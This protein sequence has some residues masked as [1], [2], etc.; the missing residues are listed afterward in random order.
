M[1]VLL[2]VSLE[3]RPP[4]QRFEEDEKLL[5]YL[6]HQQEDPKYLTKDLD[7]ILILKF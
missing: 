2:L 4:E 1:V 6:I 7:V 5:Y 3:F